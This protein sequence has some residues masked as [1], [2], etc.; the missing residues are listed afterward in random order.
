MSHLSKLIVTILL[1]IHFSGE[2]RTPFDGLCGKEL[3]DAV[4]KEATPILTYSSD[5]IWEMLY[6]LYGDGHSMIFDPFSTKKYYY[7]EK[8]HSPSGLSHTSILYP[9]WWDEKYSE[10]VKND[11]LNRLPAIIQVVEAK[12]DYPPG[13]VTVALSQ[14]E[15]WKIGIGIIQGIEVNFYQPPLNFEGDIARTAYCLICV[16]PESFWHGLGSNFFTDGNPPGFTNWTLR[17]LTTWNLNDPVSAEEKERNIKIEKIRG[18]SNPFV[19][20]PTLADHIWGEKKTIPFVSTESPGHEQRIPLHA[21]YRISDPRIDLWSPLLPENTL[22]TI[23]GKEVKKSIQ[24]K[25]YGVGIHE[26]R[27]RTDNT[28]GKLLIEI[29]Q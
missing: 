9:G 12:K 18:K 26:L 14:G 4:R 8:L 21:S 27:F 5:S 7:G 3:M 13:T 6:N 10:S 20:Y 17:Q 22:W 28:R 25:E 16:Y 11:I 19:D 2:A 29:T 23:N 24:P 1:I 15:T